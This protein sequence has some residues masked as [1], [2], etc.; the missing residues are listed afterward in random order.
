MAA[1]MKAGKFGEI[2]VL[3]LAVLAVAEAAEDQDTPPLISDNKGE[4][5]V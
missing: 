4:F 5:Y 2:F 1:K 3:M